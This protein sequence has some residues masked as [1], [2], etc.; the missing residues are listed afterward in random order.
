[1]KMND[2]RSEYGAEFIEMFT[3]EFVSGVGSQFFPEHEV[4]EQINKVRMHNYEPMFMEMLLALF[5]L[6]E[7]KYKDGLLKYQEAMQIAEFQL[8]ISD[9]H[10]LIQDRMINYLERR[11]TEKASNAAKARHAEN[12]AMKAQVYAWCDENLASRPSMD[13]AAIEIAGKLVPVGWR[14]VRKWLTEYRKSAGAG[15]TR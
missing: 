3:N 15:A 2:I 8:K 6:F 12:H 13:S 11:E 14:T 4:R 5:Q 9:K 10:T 7:S 1:M